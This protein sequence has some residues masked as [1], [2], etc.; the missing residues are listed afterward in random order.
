MHLNAFESKII[1]VWSLTFVTYLIFSN[2]LNQTQRVKIEI[3]YNDKSNIEYGIPQ[4][5]I[6]GPLLFNIDLIDLFFE[7]NDSEIYA[8]DTTPYSCAEDI[9][10]VIM[11]LQSAASKLFSWFTNN[12]MKVNSVNSGK[13]PILLSTINAIDV[14]L[15][16]A[17][18]TSSS[19]EKLLGITIDSDLKFDKH[20]SD[21]CNNISKKINAL[22]S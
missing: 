12:H 16:G 20:I 17:C 13:C 8:D 2:L 14:H 1:L 4:G 19:C 5:S 18:I 7:C 6:L 15:E 9:P 21:L 3:S 10:S 22:G 11:Q